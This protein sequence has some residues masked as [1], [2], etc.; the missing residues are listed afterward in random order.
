MAVIPVLG[1]WGHFELHRQEPVSKNQ[2]GNFNFK[3]AL[4]FFGG[5]GD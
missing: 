3:D 2:I 4:H 1:S 5:V